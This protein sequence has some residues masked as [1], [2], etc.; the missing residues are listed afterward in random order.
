MGRVLVL[1]II[2]ILLAW[3]IWRMSED[4]VYEKQKATL[5]SA[6][7]ALDLLRE[8]Y[9]EYSSDWMLVLI[10][11]DKDAVG[12]CEKC[13]ME[14]APVIDSVFRGDSA[15]RCKWCLELERI[16]HHLENNGVRRMAPALDKIEGRAA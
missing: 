7:K 2:V 9:V 15:A 3:F 12:L 8:N 14:D 4:M 5:E 10:W 1:F 13:G 16:N 6:Q 11:N